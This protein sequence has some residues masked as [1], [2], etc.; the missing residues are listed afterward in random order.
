MIWNK[1]S[2]G[3][4]TARLRWTMWTRICIATFLLGIAIFVDLKEAG[5]LSVF[6]SSPAVK[7]ILLTYLLSILYLTIPKY[8]PSPTTNVYLQSL[9]DVLLITLMVYATG[10]IRSI[11]SI[12][13]PLVIIYSVLFL[14]RRGGLVIASV[15]S[16]FYGVFAD[17]EYY[18]IIY[19]I[20]DIPFWENPLHAGYVFTRILTHIFSFYLIALLTSFVVEQ[21]KR[22]RTLLAEKQSAFDQLDILHRSI[23]ESV[24]TGIM[25]INLSSQIKS[26]N[27]SGVE[28]TGVKFREIENMPLSKIFPDF[29]IHFMEFGYIGDI[30]SRTSNNRFE[31]SF[32]SRNGSNLTLGCS[33]S[34][35]RSPDGAIIGRIIIFQD[36]TQ[37]NQMLETIEKNRKFAF[38]G[39][40]AAG[41]AHEIRNPLASITGS[42]QML[43]ED[44]TLS[45]S[46]E[47]L[48]QIILRGKDQLEGFLRDFLMM[49]RPAPG[50][51]G[52]HDIIDITREI[53]ESVRYVSE[54]QE[55]RHRVVVNLLD[56]PV[57][58]YANKAEI[59]QIL[60]NVI[61]NA[62]QAMPDGGLLKIET[63]K[64][65]SEMNQAGISLVIRDS[66]C[67]ISYCEREKIFEPFYTT[68]EMGTGLGLS[69]VK[70][71]IENYGG[72]IDIF[73][74]HGQGT[75]CTIWFPCARS[76]EDRKAIPQ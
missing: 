43:K 17:M 26:L 63:Y 29:P 57:W 1:P 32:H 39:E 64:S 20:Q 28:I 47:K 34:A 11:Y 41:L 60:W 30:K 35:L 18:G 76:N 8:L 3:D 38:I 40:M 7:I 45:E 21:E 10:G 69:V 24:E 53:L 46:N 37:I 59:R 33:I 70:R 55:D 56:H 71:L 36:L 15:A 23:I 73:S 16:I 72:G 75:T 48:M 22:T 49:T 12:F 52:E 42:I 14:G 31:W 66:G 27:R 44:L 50:V 67:G 51:R 9:F 54:W 6:F 62:I 74:I 5:S 58:V 13:Y 19:P 68:R 25:T 65:L 4:D 61:L 2:W